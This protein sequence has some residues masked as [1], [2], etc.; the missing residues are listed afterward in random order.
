MSMNSNMSNLQIHGVNTDGLKDIIETDAW[1]AAAAS[2]V[3]GLIPVLS[4]PAMIVSN[5]GAIWH[6]YIKLAQRLGVT[7]SNGLLRTLASA[8]VTN[9]TTNLAG[10]LVGELMAAFVPGASVLVCAGISYYIIYA[11]GMMFLTMLAKLLN[12]YGS[13]KAVPDVVSTDDIKCDKSY[14]KDAMKDAK[15]SFKAQKAE[16]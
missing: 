15:D 6:M 4:V 8:A 11:A 3:G 5:V 1:V 7:W 2:A 10:L 12:K 13:V 16:H 9:M 14:F